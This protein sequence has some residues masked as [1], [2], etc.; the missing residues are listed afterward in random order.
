[1]ARKAKVYIAV[2]I[3]SGAVVLLFAA[4][5]WSSTGLRQFLT[6]LGLAALSSTF[7]VRIPG[8]ESTMSPNF[9]FLVLGMVFCSFSEVIAMT[10]VAALAQSLWTAKQARL[11][12]VTFSA[13]ALVLSACVAYQAS[14]LILG[15]SAVNSPVALVILAGSLY[16]SL[17]TVLVSTVIGL[18]DGKP[19]AQIRGICYQNMVPSFMGGIAFVGLLSGAFSRP[20]AWRGAVVLIPV[21]VLG[22]LYSLSRT[23]AVARVPLRPERMEEDEEYVAMGSRLPRPRA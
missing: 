21:I 17:N 14:Y 6:F 15:Q 7:K 18:V 4:G 5:S 10:L 12:Q 16:L 3:S 11:V 9:V 20:A 1:M 8:I 2:I 13:A 22:Y 19:L 23:S